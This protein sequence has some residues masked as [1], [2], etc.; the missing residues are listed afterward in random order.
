MDDKLVLGWEIWGTFVWDCWFV[1]VW[2]DKLG[3]FIGVG[4][5]TCEDWRDIGPPFWDDKKER[6]NPKYELC[7]FL[8]TEIT[9]P[10]YLPSM[11]SDKR[12]K[13]LHEKNNMNSKTMKAYFLKGWFHDKIRI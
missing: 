2:V 6:S 7:K 11:L 9:F 12:F 3:W 8:F 4:K 5:V 1:F 13:Q 10:N